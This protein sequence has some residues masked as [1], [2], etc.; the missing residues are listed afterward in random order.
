MIKCDMC[1]KEIIPGNDKNGLPNGVG[2]EFKDGKIIIA[3]SECICALGDI[4]EEFDKFLER[5]KKEN[6]NKR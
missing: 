3:C 6:G 5:W 4:A 1:G 2:F